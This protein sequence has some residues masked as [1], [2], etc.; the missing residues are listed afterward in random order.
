MT[1][2]GHSLPPPPPLALT[3][4]SDMQSR[5]SH[6]STVAIKSATVVKDLVSSLPGEVRFQ[7]ELH[8]VLGQKTSIIRSV[9]TAIGDASDSTWALDDKRKEALA[10]AEQAEFVSKCGES[11]MVGEGLKALQVPFDCGKLDLL[12]K[13]N[14]A[15]ADRGNA[16]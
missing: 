9:L 7:K 3:C 14:E 5:F 13:R 15:N 12:E 1:L 11:L 6:L 10:S 16:K 2:G 4:K 8:D